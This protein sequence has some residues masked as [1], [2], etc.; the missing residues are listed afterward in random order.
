M[1]LDSSSNVLSV[2]PTD[3]GLM[4]GEYDPAA[5]R[6]LGNFPQA[7]SHVGLVNA[8]LRLRRG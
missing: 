4:A 8:A 6:Q 7:Y 2:L 3:V 1:A 5:G